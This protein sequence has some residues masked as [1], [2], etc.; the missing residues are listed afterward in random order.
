LGRPTRLNPKIVTFVAE[1][2]PNTDHSSLDNVPLTRVFGGAIFVS[3]FPVIVVILRSTFEGVYP[4][5]SPNPSIRS[6]VIAY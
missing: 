3:E 4:G 5:R 6:V 1:F 2:T